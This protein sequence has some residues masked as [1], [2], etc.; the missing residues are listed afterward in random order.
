MEV[1]ISYRIF[2][3]NVFIVAATKMQFTTECSHL[4]I[5]FPG[6]LHAVSRSIRGTDAVHC[7][8]CTDETRYILLERLQAVFIPFAF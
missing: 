8:D 3:I 7:I 2:F 1:Y 6:S 4:K 5:T